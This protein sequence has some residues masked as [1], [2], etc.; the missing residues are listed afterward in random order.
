MNRLDSSQAKESKSHL[1]IAPIVQVQLANSSDA[2][3][4]SETELTMAIA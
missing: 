4:E 1:G 3:I 2:T